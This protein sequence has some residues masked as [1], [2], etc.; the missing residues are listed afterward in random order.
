MVSGISHSPAKNV[1][2]I[3]AHPDDAELSS[4]GTLIKWIAKGY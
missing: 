2:V 1:L 4:A 3:M